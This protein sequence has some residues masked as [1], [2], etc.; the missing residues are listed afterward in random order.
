MPGQAGLQ[1]K[2]VEIYK[3]VGVNELNA[4]VAASDYVDI[5]A[6]AYPFKQ[7][8]KICRGDRLPASHADVWS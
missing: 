8:L 5:P 3:I 4:I 2:H 1:R 6:F 7:H